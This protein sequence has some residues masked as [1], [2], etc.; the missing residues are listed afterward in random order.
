MGAPLV[1]E[2]GDIQNLLHL[3]DVIPFDDMDN[4]TG[5]ME[6]IGA[7]YM[8][9]YWMYLRILAPTENIQY[10]MEVFRGAFTRTVEDVVPPLECGC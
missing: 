6:M 4:F 2:A 7:R 10:L 3:I 8:Q 9:A 1:L 5:I